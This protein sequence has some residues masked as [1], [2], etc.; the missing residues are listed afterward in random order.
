MMILYIFMLIFMILTTL[1]IYLYLDECSQLRRRLIKLGAPKR[2]V[3]S[4]PGRFHIFYLKELLYEKET[5]LA[6]ECFLTVERDI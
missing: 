1:G 3:M 5:E 2:E 4:F 6:E